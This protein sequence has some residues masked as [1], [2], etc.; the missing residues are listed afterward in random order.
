MFLHPDLAHGG[1]PNYSS[2]IRQ[3]MYFRVRL[4]S[5]SWP[6][7]ADIHMQDMWV[8]LQGVKSGLGKELE[9]LQVIYYPSDK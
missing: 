8:D 3:M 5:E 2:S 4:Q 6:D 7:L 9:Q 1:A